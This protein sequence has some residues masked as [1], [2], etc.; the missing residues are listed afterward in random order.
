MMPDYFNQ[1]AAIVLADEGVFSDQAADPGGATKWGVARNAHPE[2]TD[3][4]WTAWTQSDSLSLFQTKYWDAN[5]CGSMPWP[6]ALSVFDGAVN[7]GDVVIGWAQAALG[8]P[9]DN[10]VGQ[11]TLAAI[12]SASDEDLRI[13]LTLRLLSYT[14]DSAFSTYGKGWFKR[15]IGTAM[16]A[17]MT[18][19]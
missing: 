1:A 13:F 18:P 14:H 6:W 10:V 15:V 8:L 16:L 7:Q 19:S 5:Q 9:T 3:A 11:H 17:A 2:I 12:N 4:Q